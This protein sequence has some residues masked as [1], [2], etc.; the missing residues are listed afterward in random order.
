MVEAAAVEAAGGRTAEEDMVYSEYTEKMRSMFPECRLPRKVFRHGPR[1][2]RLAHLF[3]RVVPAAVTATAGPEND[4]SG[5]VVKTISGKLRIFYDNSEPEETEETAAETVLSNA[6]VE[7]DDDDDANATSAVVE[8]F[9]VTVSWIRRGLKK[10]T[11]ERLMLDSVTVPRFSRRWL[12]FD[13]LPAVK[14]WS[15]PRERGHG[16]GNWANLGLIVEVESAGMRRLA[17][18]EYIVLRNCTV[19]SEGT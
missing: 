6:T 10:G 7:E 3:F 15:R 8:K 18:E 12:A 2:P 16:H 11:S 5:N 4:S 9:R 13:V 17:A 1:D 14:E 19:G